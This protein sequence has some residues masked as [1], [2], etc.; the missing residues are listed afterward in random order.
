VGLPHLPLLA[1]RQRGRP[2]RHLIARLG[3]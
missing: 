3:K 1:A 2:C